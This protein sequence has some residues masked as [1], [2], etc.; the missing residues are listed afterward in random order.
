MH[1]KNIALLC[2][3]A[4]RL[5]Q[6]NINLLRQMVEEPD[7]LSDSKNE[8]RLLFDKQKA[9]K[10]IEELEGEQIKTARREMVLAVVGTMKAGKST[11]INAIVGQ[12]ILPNR[13]RPMTSVPTLI[14]HVPGKT[15]PVLHLEHIQPVRNLLITL[16]EKLATPAGQQVAQTLQQTGDTR[17]LLDILTDDGWLKNE[18]HGEE[19]IFTGL[20]SLN[21][22]VRL[23]AAM[24]TEFP[25]DEYAEVQKLPVIDVEFSHL[26][27]MD[28]C[29]GTLTLLDT[30][31][32][33]E[34]GQPQMEVMMRDQLQKASAVLAVMDYTQMNSK[35][36]ED[37]RKE[38]NAIAD[39][40]AGRLFVLVNKFDEKDRNGD[41]ADAVRQKVPA[42]L[43][44]DVLPASR[45]YPGSSS[46]AY[47]ANRALHE[48]RKNGTLPVDEAWVDDFVREAFGRMKKD[49]VCKDS[50]LA[51]EGATDLWECSLID[52]LIT[53]VILSS[54]SRAAALAVDSAAAKLMQNAENIS[55]YL[56]LR[57]QGLMQSIQSLQAHITSLLEDIRE[58][59]DCQE[60]VTADV[61]MAMEEIDAR[62]R[63]LL[64]G[65]C[66]SLE[67]ELNDYFRSGKRKEQ[68]MLEEE[69]S[70]QPR[71]RNA[72]AFFHDI[73]GTGNQH[74]RMR[75]FDPDS[76]E[77]KFSDRREALELMTQIE[78]TVTSLH[79]EAEAQFRPE[80]E[81]I[82]SGIETGFRGTALYATENIAG[83]INTRLED[84][85]FTVKISFPA[86]SQLQTR[87]AVKTNL[88]ALMEERTETVTRRRRQSGLWG[89]ICGAFG[90]SD[91]G[92]ETYKEDVSRS[93][94]N[95]N[96]VRK[97]VMSLTRA[98][99]G[100]LQASIEQDINQPVRQEIDAFF[101]AFR[102]KVEQLRNTLIQSSE[103][104]K[105]DQQAQ[106]RLTRRL[107]A[108][109]ERV[110]ELITDSKALREELETML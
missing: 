33:N 95:I 108:L 17:E 51:T 63:E 75:D 90:T 9:L 44:S 49:Y 64:T 83:R 82:V 74:D 20:A 23:A 28:A 43:N 69:N 31:G 40:S 93:V 11:T 72:F 80:L 89:K 5:L 66:T 107:Q 98:Y 10:R 105:R 48:L 25:F 30:P 76:P 94:I 65:V 110:P 67:E 19:E 26:V 61:R 103:D 91:W 3:E 50:E 87:L 54:H 100:E 84:E 4:D 52:Q 35:A 55:E 37:V 2:D 34:A 18:Y 68:Q 88:S 86:V 57:H 36:D 85:G 6:L 60:Q 96:T 58:I 101:C 109:N 45:V 81:K 79:R 8:N 38:L 104:H 73:F 21:D 70:A 46:Q 41:G 15:E 16:Q 1:E 106:E 14:R 32:P 102:E 62:T 42:M 77:I 29:Q 7:V 97:E 59:A 92:W 39:V 71:E 99:F 78:S 56:S 22:L 53:E 12:E 27:G 13:N 24:G 47:L